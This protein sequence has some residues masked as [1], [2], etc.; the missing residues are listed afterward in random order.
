MRST[1]PAPR[2]HVPST[3]NPSDRAPLTDFYILTWISRLHLQA[4]HLLSAADYYAIPRLRAMCERTLYESLSVE[5]SAFTL[6]LADDL[7]LAALKSESLR[8]VARNALAVMDTEGWAHLKKRKLALLEEVLRTLAAVVP[9]QAL[10]PASGG[11]G[12]SAAG[13]EAAGGRPKRKRRQP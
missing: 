8:F 3:I 1:S 10:M 7:S 12:G 9:P 4:Q 5:N 6:T 11:A 13:A 2:R